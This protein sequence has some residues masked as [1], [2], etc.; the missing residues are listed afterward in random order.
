MSYEWILLI[1]IAI[2]SIIVWELGYAMGSVKLTPGQEFKVYYDSTIVVEDGRTLQANVINGGALSYGIEKFGSEELSDQNYVL[3]DRL[4]IQEGDVIF[5]DILGDGEF[6]E[7]DGEKVAKSVRAKILIDTYKFY[8]GS[9]DQMIYDAKI[10]LTKNYFKNQEIYE[11]QVKGQVEGKSELEKLQIPELSTLLED[12][13]DIEE[14]IL[15]SIDDQKVSEMFKK[16]NKNNNRFREQSAIENGIKWEKQRIVKLCENVL[17]FEEFVKNNPDA[18][19]EY[20]RYD[21]SQGE[22]LSQEKQ[23]NINRFGKETEIFGI[24]LSKLKNGLELS[25]AMG[26]ENPKDP[27]KVAD[28]IVVMTFDFIKYQPDFQFE[29]LS[30][31]CSTM[32]IY[33]AED[34]N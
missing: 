22:Y 27:N 8:I 30:F 16:I 10:Y 9:L 31:V 19:F 2:V 14:K 12:G 17:Y 20:T 32:R 28:G 33:N 25:K 3:A 24:N 6:E 26:L 5:T 21:Q 15:N 4:S 29:S 23:K 18:L 13:K 34:N 1:I 11:N 7:V